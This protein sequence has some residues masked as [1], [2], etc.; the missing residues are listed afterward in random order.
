MSEAAVDDPGCEFP[1]TDAG[2]RLVNQS[3]SGQRTTSQS[4]S[5]DLVS[6]LTSDVENVRMFLERIEAAFPDLEPNSFRV[7]V[8]GSGGG[9][10]QEKA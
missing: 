9:A 3:L 5:G 10:I 6:R 4:R 7:F 8:T 2:E 1:A